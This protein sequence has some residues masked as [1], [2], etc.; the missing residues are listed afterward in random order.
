MYI[1]KLELNLNLHGQLSFS[2]SGDLLTIIVEGPF[3]EV[4]LRYW[5]AEMQKQVET[6]GL[7]SW[8]RF[9]I[10]DDESLSSP[11]GLSVVKQLYE[12]YEIKGCVLSVFVVKNSMQEYIIRDVSK[13]KPEI[14]YDLEHAKKWM[15]SYA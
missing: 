13:I 9:E 2:W 4:G 14:F 15:A 5:F 1:S 12:W 6:K 7:T 3:N 10:W 11:E 8:R